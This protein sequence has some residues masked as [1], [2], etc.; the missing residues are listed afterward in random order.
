MLAGCFGIVQPQ[1]PAQ[2]VADQRTPTAPVGRIETMPHDPTATPMT[3]GG[4]RDETSQTSTPNATQTPVPTSI[5]TSTVTATPTA[6]PT[7]ASDDGPGF[8]AGAA[9]VAVLAAALL[10][11]R[12]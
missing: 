12:R 1:E 7:E 11:R 5:L 3:D 4:A 6:T 9:V 10:F 8:T 2:A